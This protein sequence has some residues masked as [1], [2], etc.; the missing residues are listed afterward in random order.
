[1]QILLVPLGLSLDLILVQVGGAFTPPSEYDAQGTCT[2]NN[3][4]EITRI[5][6]LC[7]STVA[8]QFDCKEAS[9]QQQCQGYVWPAPFLEPCFT[10]TNQYM[11]RYG[12][13]IACHLCRAACAEVG[14]TTPP[15][16]LQTHARHWA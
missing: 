11:Q 14:N 2:P 12:R 7:L 9:W 4:G 16:Q 8:V 6:D 10:F 13:V 5:G 1:M 3:N 15:L